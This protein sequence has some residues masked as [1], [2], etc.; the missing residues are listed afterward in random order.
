MYVTKIVEKG[1]FAGADVYL[2]LDV[3]SR[4]NG[5]KKDQ[6]HE[7]EKQGMYSILELGLRERAEGHIW[8]K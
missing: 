7:K 1:K 8:E 4:T 5:G 6:L 3:W 2:S